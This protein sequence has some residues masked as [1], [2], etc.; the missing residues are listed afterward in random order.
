M[1]VFG[2]DYSRLYDRFYYDKD[3]V[4]ESDT[5]CSILKEY[6]LKSIDPFALAPHIADIGCGTG[7]HLSLMI[8]NLKTAGINGHYYAI[9][10]SEHMLKIAAEKLHNNMSDVSIL[11][12]DIRSVQVPNKCQFVISLSSVIGYLHTNEEL[13]RAFRNIRKAVNTGGV[14]VFDVWY[15]P[16]VLRN[17]VGERIKNIR[18]QRQADIMQVSRKSSGKL[19]INNNLCHVNYDFKS[20]EFSFAE[21]HTV[22]YFFPVELCELLR[23]SGFAMVKYGQFPNMSIKPNFESWHMGVVAEAL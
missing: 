8:D 5:V 19:D 17:G 4:A 10:R 20:P 14:F 21:S 12:G 9:D 3:Y 2:Q 23:D 11:D 6:I 1:D 18:I 16:A 22:R 15:G 7:T 13:L